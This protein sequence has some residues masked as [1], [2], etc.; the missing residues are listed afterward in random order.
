MSKNPEKILIFSYQSVRVAIIRKIKKEVPL[1]HNL[2]GYK[3]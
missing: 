1:S 3:F 2:I